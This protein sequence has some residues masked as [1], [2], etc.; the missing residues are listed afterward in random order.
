MSGTTKKNRKKGVAH[1][2]ELVSSASTSTFEMQALL[3][4][5]PVPD[6]RQTVQQYLHSCEAL[7]TPD[8]MER[9]RR[10]AGAFCDEAVSGPLQRYVCC[11]LVLVC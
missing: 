11:L 7:M 2:N 4:R 5:L 8:E 9:T 6:V 1:P 3:P 10:V